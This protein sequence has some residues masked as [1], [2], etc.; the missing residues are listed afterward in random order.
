LIE[1]LADGRTCRLVR[2]YYPTGRDPLPNRLFRKALAEIESRGLAGFAGKILLE[3]YEATRSF[4]LACLAIADFDG[5][6]DKPMS[7]RERE[8]IICGEKWARLWDQTI[9]LAKDPMKTNPGTQPGTMKKPRGRPRGSLGEFANQRMA[10]MMNHG[11]EYST[12]EEAADAYKDQHEN[13]LEA[14]A[15]AMRHAR[16]ILKK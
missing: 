3:L 15:D 14:D 11:D 5:F 9:L 4:G 7:Q 12:L 1:G 10:F 13:D 6:D 16:D 8:V 2:S